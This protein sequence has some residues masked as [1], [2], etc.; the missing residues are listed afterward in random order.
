MPVT[1]FEPLTEEE[2]E[3]LKQSPRGRWVETLREFLAGDCP[4]AR[5]IHDIENLMNAYRAIQQAIRSHDDI[6][7]LVFVTKRGDDIYLV[8]T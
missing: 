6:K 8:R 2:R 5:V 4:A 3:S 7:G 1:M